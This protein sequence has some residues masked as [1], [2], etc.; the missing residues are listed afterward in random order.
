MEELSS[1]GVDPMSAVPDWE[2][3]MRYRGQSHE[4]TVPF[5]VC[6]GPT[7]EDLHR[8]HERAYGHAMVDERV[9]VVNVRLKLRV[10]GPDIALEPEEGTGGEVPCRT[11]GVLFEEGWHDASTIKRDRLAA[12]CAGTGPTVIEGEG[13]TVVV[14]PGCAWRVDGWGNIW[15]EVA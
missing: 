5:H 9:E 3:D 13:E 4:L 15:L 7:E 6:S 2:V 14:P 10:T 11:R 1:A 12:G 8:A